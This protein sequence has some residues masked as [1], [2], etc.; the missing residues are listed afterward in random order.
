MSRIVYQFATLVEL[1]RDPEN[2]LSIP[3]DLA[4]KYQDKR[5]DVRDLNGG[6]GLSFYD[7]YDQFVGQADEL[8]NTNV[9]DDYDV[10]VVERMKEIEDSKPGDQLFLEVFDSLRGDHECV[11]GVF[12]DE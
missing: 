5:L 3:E 6:R 8:R 1:A 2:T 7:I 4:E 9:M 11:Y 12:K 10:T